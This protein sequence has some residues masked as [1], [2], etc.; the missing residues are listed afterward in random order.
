MTV[1]AR[2]EID[3]PIELVFEWFADLKRWP[4]VLVDT[5]AVE[6]LYFDGYNEE[7]TM[8]VTRPGGDETVRGV[9]Y[10]RA[11]RELE[12]FQMTPPPGVLAMSGV[13]NFDALDSNRTAVR[14][15]RNVELVDPDPS[16]TEAFRTRLAG[17]LELNLLSF[18]GAIERDS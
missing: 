10:H 3:A 5:K 11:P 17:F 12:L 4:S 2:V 6:V 14:A 16:S 18:K 7:F 13:W 9:R 15:T 8:T 1:E